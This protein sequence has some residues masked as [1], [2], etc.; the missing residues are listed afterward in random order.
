MKRF[1]LLAL[2]LLLLPT[3]TSTTQSTEE[4]RSFARGSWKHI[5]EKHAGQ[6]TVVHFWGLTCGPCRVEMPMWGKLLKKHPGLNLVTIDAD[7]VPNERSA[8]IAMLT[9]AGLAGAENWM[10]TDGFVERLRFE[11]DPRWQGEIPMTLLIASDGTITTSEGVADFD[12]IEAWLATHSQP[13][14]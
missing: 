13:M 9:N 11:V 12:A 4:L 8:V 5:R 10:F 3:V 1:A 6:P 2:L 7:L 14:R